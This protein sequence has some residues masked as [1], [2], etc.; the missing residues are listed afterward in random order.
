MSGNDII[1]G[2]GILGTINNMVTFGLGPEEPSEI[3]G[4]GPFKTEMVMDAGMVILGPVVAQHILDG[5]NSNISLGLFRYAE[6]AFD[7]ELGEVNH[8]T[9]WSEKTGFEEIEDYMVL[10]DEVQ[11]WNESGFDNEDWGFGI[12]SGDLYD[13]HLRGT[14]NAYSVFTEED[15][16]RLTEPPEESNLYPASSRGLYFIVDINAVEY[17]KIYHL[18][19]LEISGGSAG[20]LG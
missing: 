20:R 18:A 13:V 5:L 8:L 9:V 19:G 10:P 16:I 3:V 7:D 12:S 11:D 1:V 4:E 14:N 17:P 6:L 2:D 15:L